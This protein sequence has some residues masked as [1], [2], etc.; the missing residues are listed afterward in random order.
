MSSTFSSAAMF[1]PVHLAPLLRGRSMQSRVLCAAE[2]QFSHAPLRYLVA[3]YTLAPRSYQVLVSVTPSFQ[4]R[5]C[6]SDGPSF[7]RYHGALAMNWGMCGLMAFP[8]SSTCGVGGGRAGAWHG[9][10]PAGGAPPAPV[11]GSAVGLKQRSSSLPLCLP[12]RHTGK[13]HL[14]PL[15]LPPSPTTTLAGKA[16]QSKA[17]QGKARLTSGAAR[18]AFRASSSSFCR[19][20]SSALS[21]LPP[22]E[23]MA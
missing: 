5:W 15:L 4:L 8:S 1:F 16:K 3:W 21:I 10:A 6:F 23:A 12:A 7:D 2:P 14:S 18:P 20:L 22:A 13:S 11:A 17:K 19:R 9:L